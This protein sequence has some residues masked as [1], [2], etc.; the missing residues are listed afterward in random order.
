MLKYCP[1]DW[2]NAINPYVSTPRVL[3]KYGNVSMGII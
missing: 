2:A 3:T 1:K